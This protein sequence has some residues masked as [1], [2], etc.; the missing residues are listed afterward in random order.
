[1]K[2]LLV[3]IGCLI[4]KEKGQLIKKIVFDQ[5]CKIWQLYCAR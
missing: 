4:S 2:Y 5:I 1:L 3:W